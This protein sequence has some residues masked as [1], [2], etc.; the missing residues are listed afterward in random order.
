MS[1]INVTGQNFEKEVLHSDKPVLVD[2]WAPWCGPC[3]ML[4]PVI[5]E[6]AEEH[7]EI[8][9]CKVNVDNEMDLASSFHIASIPMLVVM[10]DGKVTNT[11]VG[12]RPKE[13]IVNMI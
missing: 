8:K 3:K 7:P 12:Y 13:Q 5:A 10:K 11:A 6:I 4:G 1:E 9:V 2:F